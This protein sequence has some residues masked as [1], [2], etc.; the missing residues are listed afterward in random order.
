MTHTAYQSSLAVKTIIAQLV[1]TILIPIL[2]NQF[3]KINNK[4][5]GKGGIDE[6]IFYIG[7][8]NSF[9]PPIIKIID[10]KYIYFK[11]VRVWWYER[12]GNF[13]LYSRQKV[14]PDSKT[15]QPSL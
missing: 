15:A 4:Y 9:L 7:I 8:T 10:P 2:V 14:L 6:E 3:V 12:P 11:Y 5:Y 1:N 13:F